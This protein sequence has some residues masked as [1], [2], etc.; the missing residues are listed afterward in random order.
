MQL[1]IHLEGK[2]LFDIFCSTLRINL[3]LFEMYVLSKAFQCVL[4]FLSQMFSTRDFQPCA[5]C[6]ACRIVAVSGSTNLEDGK[7]TQNSPYR[8]SSLKSAVSH[9]QNPPVSGFIV[10]VCIREIKSGGAWSVCFCVAAGLLT[11]RWGQGTVI[12][13]AEE[14]RKEEKE[15]EGERQRESRDEKQWEETGVYITVW[16]TVHMIYRMTHSYF[17]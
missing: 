7:K 16:G 15:W 10:S 5:Q 14:D 8:E 12:R 17:K 13:P 11:A 3:D 6:K 1:L 2:T 9:T 4:T